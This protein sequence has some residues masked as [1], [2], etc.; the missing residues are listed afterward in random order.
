MMVYIPEASL[1]NSTQ[2]LVQTAP[3]PGW[4]EV[5][6]MG[7]VVTF[8]G[9][10]ASVPAASIT[11]TM[12]Y[13]QL[14][15]EVQSMPVSFGFVGKP[16]SAGVVNV[17]VA[18]A[19]TVPASLAGTVVFDTTLTTSSAVFTLN[20]ISAGVTSALGTITITSTNHTSATLSGAGGS[21]A[22]GDVLQILAP[23]QDSTLADLG[24][25]VLCARV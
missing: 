1:T 6:T 7:D 16:A 23:T 25:T 22:I 24:I 18:M 12:T 2:V 15:G 13:A 14:P 4:D 8:V 11:G 19:M 20:K 9:A 5:T 17:P 3:S 21:V 10:S